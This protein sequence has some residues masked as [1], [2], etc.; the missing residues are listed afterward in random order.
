MTENLLIFDA[1]EEI[2]DCAAEKWREI[3]SAAV[4]R[5]GVFTAALSGGR[6]PEPF[7]RKL[8]VSPGLPWKETNL[9]LVD[10]RFVPADH[11]DSNGRMVRDALVDPVTERTGFSPGNFHTIPTDLP[12]ASRAAEAYEGALRNFFG[13]PGKTGPGDFPS[14]DLIVLGIGEDGHTASLFPGDPAI[15]EQSRIA[16][17]VSSADPQKHDRITLTLPVLNRAKNAI[18]LLTGGK[19]ASILTRILQKDFSLPA[20]L[21]HPETGNLLILAD[22]AAGSEVRS[23]ILD[24]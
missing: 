16:A 15:K 9:F 18:F 14:F 5:D 6:T 20:S 24:T 17:P 23:E 13:L 19:K 4:Q 3:A 10:E 8:A 21:V 7:Y 2:A 22:A 1:I 11:P 12:S